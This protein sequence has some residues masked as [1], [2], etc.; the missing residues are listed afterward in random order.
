MEIS[1]MSKLTQLWYTTP[2]FVRVLMEVGFILAL[3]YFGYKVYK[4]VRVVFKE[5]LE[6]K[7]LEELF[8]LLKPLSVMGMLCILL[9]ATMLPSLEVSKKLNEDSKLT[10]TS[11]VLEIV[12]TTRYKAT[13]KTEQGII[14]LPAQTVAQEFVNGVDVENT[15]AQ[16]KEGDIIE[17]T[18]YEHHKVGSYITLED[19]KEGNFESNRIIM[20]VELLERKK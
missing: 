4:A 8:T 1:E 12:N 14:N 17:H 7:T 11:E 20:D 10:Q 18:T 16:L 6:I 5:D 2:V 15:V 19:I 9:L 3:I 13:I